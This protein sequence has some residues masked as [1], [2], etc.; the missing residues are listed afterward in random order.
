MCETIFH[1]E[2]FSLE[3]GLTALI[4]IGR[5][6]IYVPCKK[7]EDDTWTPGETSGKILRFFNTATIEGSP[8]K[9]IKI[10]IKDRNGTLEP[11]IKNGLKKFSSKEVITV[12]VE[13]LKSEAADIF[14]VF[15]T[16]NGKGKKLH[17][18]R[19]YKSYTGTLNWGIFPEKLKAAI[20]SQ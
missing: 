4:K 3:F 15:R 8:K 5:R 10:T 6:K 18:I 7:N 11:F 17:V 13:N 20:A 12:E 14:K 16:K 1:L 9:H 2:K 19:D